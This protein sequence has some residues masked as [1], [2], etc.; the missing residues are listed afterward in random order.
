MYVYECYLELQNTRIVPIYLVFARLDVWEGIFLI[1]WGEE[2]TISCVEVQSRPD[3]LL[4]QDR[5][6]GVGI[7]VCIVLCSWL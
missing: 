3:I 1:L 7:H 6:D 2:G 4:L 5:A